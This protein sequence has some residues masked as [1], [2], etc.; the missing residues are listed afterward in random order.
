M[1]G[2]RATIIDSYSHLLQTFDAPIQYI[3]KVDTVEALA[4]YDDIKK[5]SDV[6]QS[7]LTTLIAKD[8]Q[9]EFPMVHNL[10]V[11]KNSRVAECL[12]STGWHLRLPRNL[13][14]WEIED[15]SLLLELLQS[16]YLHSYQE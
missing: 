2:I 1:T 7:C 10:E 9:N 11:N 16:V 8:S 14:D 12:S 3:E 13:N 15:F 6:A 5:I 4:I